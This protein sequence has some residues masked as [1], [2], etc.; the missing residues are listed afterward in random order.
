MAIATTT[1][2]AR[3]VSAATISSPPPRRIR[4]PTDVKPHRACREE[5]SP[6]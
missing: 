3:V 6:A 4:L 5:L 2:R 1:I